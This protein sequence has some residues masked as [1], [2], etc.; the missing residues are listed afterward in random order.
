MVMRR[1]IVGNPGREGADYRHYTA[2]GPGPG[3]A[4]N[5]KKLGFVL[6]DIEVITGEEL[7][8]ALAQQYGYRWST[9]LPA[10]SSPPTCSAS[11]RWMWRFP[12]LFFPSRSRTAGLP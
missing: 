2:T 3:Q 5:R 7:S 6:E 10:S 8:A 1:K 11:F 12:I 4:G 9:T